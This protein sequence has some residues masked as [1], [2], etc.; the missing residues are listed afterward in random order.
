MGEVG[1]RGQADDPGGQIE[2]LIAGSKCGRQCEVSTRRLAGYHHVLGAVF[3]D[4]NP[5]DRYCFVE[6]D[7]ER[8]FRCSGVFG[9]NDTDI[10]VHR[11][12]CGNDNILGGRPD[13]E[14]A[15]EEVENCHVGALAAK[16]GTKLA[17]PHPRDRRSGFGYREL[18]TSG[19]NFRPETVADLGA[20][21]I[22]VVDRDGFEGDVGVRPQPVTSLRTGSRPRNIAG[23]VH[24]STIT[25]S[26]VH[27]QKLVTLDVEGVLV[28]EVWVNLAQRTGIDE[29]LRT[30]R[31]E[32]DY[33]SLMQYRLEILDA[34]G[35]NMSDLRAVLAAMGPFDGAKEFLDDLRADY[36]VVLLSDT[37]QEFASPLMHQL[38][39]PTI[40]CHQLRVVDDHIVDYVQRIDDHKRRAVEAFRSLNYHVVSAGDSYNDLSMLRSAHAGALLYAP[41]NI[42]AENPDLAS[43]TDYGSLRSWID[44]AELGPVES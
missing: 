18:F 33:D 22:G 34:N 38:G 31:D 10:E 23:E 11:Q 24:R 5:I 1:P 43:F 39:C 21:P 32:A 6:G 9:G 17:A 26:G 3:I 19:E 40:L 28:P 12:R 44:A 30:T 36:Q 29:L 41:A 8:G 7:G 14:A 2:T 27:P 20:N 42:I 35:V 13:R 25:I 16:R 15:A 4:E 37:F